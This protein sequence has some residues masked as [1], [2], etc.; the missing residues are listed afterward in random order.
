MSFASNSSR[1]GGFSFFLFSSLLT[2][3][4]GGLFVTD[5]KIL[6]LVF[7]YNILM[8]LAGS[9]IVWLDLFKLQGYTFCNKDVGS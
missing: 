9:Y 8:G 1:E 5:V 2:V 6:W 4:L 3:M 7:I